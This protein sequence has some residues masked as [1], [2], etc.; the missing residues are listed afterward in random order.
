M[1]SCVRRPAHHAFADAHNDH[2]DAFHDD[3]LFIIIR[4]LLPITNCGNRNCRPGVSTTDVLWSEAKGIFSTSQVSRECSPCFRVSIGRTCIGHRWPSI[5]NVRR[6]PM[7][8]AQSASYVANGEPN[9]SFNTGHKPPP[10]PQVPFRV[11]QP[12]HIV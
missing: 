4:L 1:C 3:A 7:C 9:P 2:N 10:G 6:S 8:H 5:R 11:A 12:C